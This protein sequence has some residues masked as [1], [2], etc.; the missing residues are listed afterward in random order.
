MRRRGA[1]TAAFAAVMAVAFLVAVTQLFTMRL[2]QGTMFPPY[3]TFRAD[4][5]GAKAFYEALAM[6]DGISVRRDTVSGAVFRPETALTFFMLG[7]QARF[8]DEPMPV[9][10]FEYFERVAMEGGRV[11]LTFHPI[12]EDPTG[13]WDEELPDW[14]KNIG[15]MHE[16]EEEEEEDSGD[17]PAGKEQV[18][19]AAAQDGAAAESARDADEIAKEAVRRDD[20]GARAGAGSG[21]AADGDEDIEA[22]SEDAGAN[23][24]QDEDEDNEDGRYEEPRELIEDRWGVQVAFA[25]LDKAGEE[26]AGTEVLREDAGDLPASL[27]WHSAMAFNPL[28]DSWRVLYSRASGEPVL[29]ERA[30]GPGTLVLCSDS[31]FLSN[32]AM[33]EARQPALLAYLVGPH[34]TV[35]FDETH[36]GIRQRQGVMAL[37]RRYGLQGFMV[38]LAAVCALFVWRNTS[39]LAPPHA[40]G[41]VPHAVEHDVDRDAAA[42]LRNLLRRSV[43]RSALLDACVKEWRKS[44]PANRPG[45]AKGVARV[46]TIADAEK[47]RPAGERNAVRAYREMAEALKKARG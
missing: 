12:G 31:F 29:I 33:L 15:R 21:D 42:A 44:L 40:E 10:F 24:D 32:E 14:V 26:Y 27:P 38:A 20:K 34:P 43:G 45:L 4:A 22:K 13:A 41:E 37:A 19:G 30:Y 17:A 35:V 36:F 46:Q 9:S 1:M 47:K 3:S 18:D 8:M 2:E 28:V 39:S 25:S 5:L 11:V 7:L 6:Q 16:D 23:D